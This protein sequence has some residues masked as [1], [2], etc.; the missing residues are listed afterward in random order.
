MRTVTWRL[1]R[2]PAG[3]TVRVKTMA[4]DRRFREVQ[5]Y[6]GVYGFLGGFP[7]F[8]EA[9][10]GDSVVYGTILLRDTEAEWRDVPRSEYQVLHVE[11]VP[12]MFRAA[13][14]YAAREGYD[15]AFPNC[16]QADH[17]QGV[18]YGTI[19]M[20][21][22]TTERR[23]VLRGELGDPQ[24]D[25]VPAM[26][27]AANDYSA[28]EGFAAAFPTFNQASYGAGVVYG[29]VLLKAGVS[30]WRDVPADL[31]AMYS[32]PPRRWAILLC[33][34]NDRPPA[35]TSRDRYVEFFTEAGAGT[36]SAYDYWRDMSYG[37][38]GLVG[39]QV[40][41]FFEIPHASADLL[42]ISGP[43]QRK[44]AFDWGLDAAARGHVPLGDFDH[45][46]VVLNGGGNDHGK[47][48]GGVT[49]VY[50][51][52][53]ALEPTFMFHELGHEFG[54][55]HSFSDAPT[56]C[57]S[58]D[59]RPGAYCDPSDIM[60]AMAV[61]SFEDARNR[62]SG[63][64]LNAVSRKRLGWLHR[65]RIRSR[66]AAAA[67][68]ALTLAAVDRPD[69]DGYQMVEFTGTTRTD[70]SAQ[71][72]YTV[73]FRERAGWDR[74]IPA[75]KVLVHEIQSDGLV[76]LLTRAPIGTLAAG[77]EFVSPT[78]S[79][80]VRVGSI[81][82]ASHTA[83]L[84]I[85]RLPRSGQ[86][87]VRITRILYDPVGPEPQGEYVLIENDR[88]VT[89]DLTDWTLEDAA[90]HKYSFPA[91]ALVPGATVKVWTGIGTND[92]E[93]LF[94]GRRAAIWNNTGDVATLRDS[95]GHEISRV[96]YPG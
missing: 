32:A 50:A 5:R 38:G 95:A 69:V 83:A 64:G 59:G 78:P 79:T 36:E 62:R 47:T 94:M 84:R 34:L 54:L 92:A 52:E 20:K 3:F 35:A 89:A 48:T 7:N 93:N 85:W 43:P 63:P 45:K 76:R 53:T 88:F 28:R 37:I 61:A 17:S 30:T 1:Q 12:A 66:P 15:A 26:M 4:A 77:E 56:P 71:S 22:G 96:A 13:N 57:A 82:A 87:E 31:L 67:P 39:T 40:F 70:P 24:P 42:A 86:R 91:F 49:F 51:D 6:A 16:E 72:T 41:G 81:D 33:N 44:Q 21:P 73:E 65:S 23:D 27:R 75:S 14:D 60:S 58:G 8:H 25:D 11:D 29:I 18:V 10:Y 9:D 74:G 46:V 55:D 90:G 2:A 80:V 68:E 19:L